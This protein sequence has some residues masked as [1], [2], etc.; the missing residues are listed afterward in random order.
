MTVIAVRD[1]VMAADSRATNGDVP[2]RCEKI[3]RIGRQL[4]GAAGDNN[5]C[6]AY[7]RYFRGEKVE[8]EELKGAHALVLSPGGLFIYEETTAADP[9]LEEFFAIGC[10][11]D[12]ALGA[13]QYGASA[14]QAVD[15]ACRWNV[16]CGP[17]VVHLTLKKRG[18]K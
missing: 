5:A 18:A 12:A 3:Y 14:I 15:A 10:G 8:P 9:V 7:V 1:G 13:M 11:S 2:Y 17:P 4:V 6:L 16:Q